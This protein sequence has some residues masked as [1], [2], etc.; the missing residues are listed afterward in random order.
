MTAVRATF[1]IGALFDALVAVGM[2]HPPL[3]AAALGV[4]PTPT[5]V[6]ARAALAMAAALMVGW[7][8]LL[9]WGSLRPVERRGVLVLTVCPVIV[10]LALA[11]LYA[12]WERYVPLSGAAGVWASQLLLAAIFLSGY[13][14]ASRLERRAAA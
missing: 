6:D 4:G 13:R 5:A 11:T 12:A 2:L 10:G 14:R 8:A 3:L 1:W 9:L 7:T